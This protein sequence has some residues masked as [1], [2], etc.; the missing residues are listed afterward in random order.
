M[1]AFRSP[2][3]AGRLLLAPLLFSTAIAGCNKDNGDGPSTEDLTC[4]AIDP[5][6]RRIWRL[7]TQQFSNSVR[8][9]LGLDTAP[10]LGTL[11]GQS[12]YAFFA[13][14]TLTVDPQLSYNINSVLRQT[15]ATVSM[16]ALAAC[17]SGEADAAC[18]QRFAGTF[19]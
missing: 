4:S 19:R 15:L 16:P 13:D 12:T 6:P 7:S 8:D 14:A 11:G 1:R 10:D 17:Q 18:A 9:L 3:R 2:G 5:L